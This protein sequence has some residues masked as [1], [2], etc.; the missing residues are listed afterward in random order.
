MVDPGCLASSS[1]GHPGAR[2]ARRMKIKSRITS[3]PLPF[4]AVLIFINVTDSATP[5]L[6]ALDGVL[7]PRQLSA[8]V[9]DAEVALFQS[10]FLGNGQNKNGWPTTSFWP[11]AARATDYQ[12]IDSGVLVSVNQIGVRQRYA[13]GAIHPTAGHVFLTIPACAEA[14]GHLAGEFNNLKFASVVINGNSRFALVE[15]DAIPSGY[16]GNMRKGR[17][18]FHTERGG[19]AVYF[20]LARSVHQ[21]PD[22]DVLPSD[23]TIQSVARNTINQIVEL[24]TK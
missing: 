3:C 24:A 22:P 13:G 2:F 16:S 21:A 14:Y 7:S 11:R 17:R 1:T 6:V 19:G 9:G 20:W 5:A 8:S 4:M 18:D 15:A 10:H 23:Q 12:V